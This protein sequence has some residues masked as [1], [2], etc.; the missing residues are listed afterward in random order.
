MSDL[1][2]RR[3]CPIADAP[4]S[5]PFAMPPGLEMIPEYAVLREEAP[6]TKVRLP[7]GEA[8]LV[9]RYADV[10]RIVTDSRFSRALACD[11]EAPRI[12]A[13][14][15]PNTSI[16]S[17]DPPQHTRLRSIVTREFTTRRVDR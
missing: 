15:L 11:P 10:R 6:I 4:P 17:M 12:T 5:F 8:W 1:D 2:T 16:I 9:T 14:P 13:V 7:Q 3:A